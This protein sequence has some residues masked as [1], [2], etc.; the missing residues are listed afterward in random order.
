VAGWIVVV[1]QEAPVLLIRGAVTL[2]VLVVIS[3]RVE[4]AEVQAVQADHPAV[5]PEV[6]VT[7]KPG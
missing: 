5:V 3:L 2:E 4:E 7:I 1:R 6:G